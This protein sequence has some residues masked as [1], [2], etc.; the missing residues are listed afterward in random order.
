MATPTGSAHR[1]VTLRVSSVENNGRRSHSKAPLDIC[2]SFMANIVF[3]LVYNKT[4]T[5]F[6]MSLS[7]ILAWR[8]S[9]AL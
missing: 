6:Y 2:E 1:V 4:E 8:P 7:K 9:F 5:T 3:L